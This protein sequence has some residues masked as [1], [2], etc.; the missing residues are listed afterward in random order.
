METKINFSQLPQHYSL[1]LN[2]KCAKT[3][4][5]LRQLVEQ[6]VPKDIQHFM[7]INP[8]Y[9]ASLEGPCP[10]YRPAIKVRFAKGFINMLESLPY[11][12]MQ[13]VISRLTGNFSRRTYYRI[14]KGERLLSPSEQQKILNILKNCGISHPGEFDAYIEEYDW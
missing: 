13:A 8:A 6:I 5:C 12:Q 3:E 2:R 14:R 7:I 9:L 4:T 10:H 1:C 11:K